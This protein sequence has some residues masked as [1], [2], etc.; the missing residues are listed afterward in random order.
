MLVMVV[1]ESQRTILQTYFCILFSFSHVLSPFSVL[2]IS[3]NFF[4]WFVRNK[5]VFQSD[6]TV[7]DLQKDESYTRDF[8]ADIWA[9]L[10]QLRT[11]AVKLR[12][13]RVSTLFQEGEFTTY[14]QHLLFFSTRFFLL[15]FYFLFCFFFSVSSSSSLLHFFPPCTL[16]LSAWDLCS[17]ISSSASSLSSPPP[18]SHQSPVVLVASLIRHLLS[19]YRREGLW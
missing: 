13:R 16:C 8:R 4:S 17:F 18:L 6:G 5:I 11:N 14:L 3:I 15:Q 1:S 7:K 19:A 12:L 2:H 9:R 10:Q